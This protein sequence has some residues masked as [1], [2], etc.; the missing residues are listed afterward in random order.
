MKKIVLV[1]TLLMLVMLS[2]C[3]ASPTEEVLE[4]SAET[5]VPAVAATPAPAW[6][7]TWISAR[8]VF[9]GGT[10]KIVCIKLSDGDNTYLGTLI[11]TKLKQGWEL[12][13]VLHTSD[14]GGMIQ[15]F[16]F[17]KPFAAPA[18]QE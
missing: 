4:K 15:T 11:T 12:D 2:A 5:L 17:R 10:N 9:D 13:E 7:Y 14:P 16:I 3:K 1:I 6:D 8:C 18:A